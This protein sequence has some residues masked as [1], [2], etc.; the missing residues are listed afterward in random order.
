MMCG[1]RDSTSPSGAIFTSTPGS[2]GPTVPGRL[3]LVRL[4]VMTGELSVSP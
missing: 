1:P 4:N 2:A 3:R